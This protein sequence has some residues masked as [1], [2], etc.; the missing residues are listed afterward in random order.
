MNG[1]GTVRIL[2]LG[3]GV[4][5]S[6]LAL[7]MK[8]GELE[9][10]EAAVFSDVKAEPRKVYQWLNWLEKQLPFPVIRVTQD[11]GLTANIEAY[12]SGRAKRASI[13]PLFTID[14]A[15]KVGAIRR[16]CTRDFKLAPIRRAVR[17][18]AAGRNVVQVIGISWDERQRVRPSDVGYIRNEYPLVERQMT[19]SDCKAWM[20]K[21]FYSTP[22]RSA[23]VY[24]PYK[25]DAE[26]RLLRDDDPEGWQ[27]AVR[28]DL[29]MRQ[30][31]HLKQSTFVHRSCVPLG[32]V[33][34]TSDEERGQMTFA[35]DC[36]G[37]CGV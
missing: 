32:E 19:R 17:K 13:P 37:M 36:E 26:W 21:H 6:T 27:E 5:S 24:C 11:E 23:C 15:G 2:S 4:Q 28:M 8:H 30:V 12:A 25:C 18:I 22:P 9:G 20:F 29:L 3:A 7:M 10:V 16:Q 31:P 1:R 14:D 33:D 34:L 35:F